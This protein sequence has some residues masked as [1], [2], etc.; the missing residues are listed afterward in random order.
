MLLFY[1]LLIFTVEL[2]E[3]FTLIIIIIIVIIIIINLTSA[4]NDWDRLTGDKAVE[5]TL[6]VAVKT[7]DH[8]IVT[9]A[10]QGEDCSNAALTDHANL[11]KKKKTPS[12]LK[13]D[14]QPDS[15]M[16]ERGL[17]ER[18]VWGLRDVNALGWGEIRIVCNINK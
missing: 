5:L 11:S 1:A 2:R 9:R 3:L 17:R 16:R 7:I 8:S 13:L 6:G 14:L 12:L 18:K 10:T 15:R 4:L